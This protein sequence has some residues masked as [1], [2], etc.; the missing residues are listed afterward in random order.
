LVSTRA[1]RVNP[2]S[3]QELRGRLPVSQIIPSAKVKP[4]AIGQFG[5]LTQS[6]G[7]ID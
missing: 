2:A 1:H 7:L 5:R 4:H 3:R 6:Y